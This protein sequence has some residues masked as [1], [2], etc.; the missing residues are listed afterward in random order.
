MTQPV[1]RRGR[2][3]VA[4]LGSSTA[5]GNLCVG[6]LWNP[7]GSKDVYVTVMS[8]AWGASGSAHYV[9]RITV[10]GTPASSVVPDIDND[11]DALLA[12]ISG[13]KLDLGAYSVQPTKAGPDVF[14]LKHNQNNP[15]PCEEIWF[16]NGIRL[17]AG[18][19]LGIFN[20]VAGSVRSV[21]LSFTW[22][23]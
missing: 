18:T 4:G 21:D 12:P 1:G 6:A 8:C 5:A 17:E 23:E 11:L 14:R 13:V 19:G 3:T 16:G 20:Q 10:E 9:Q 2:Y 22:D 7:H 15:G